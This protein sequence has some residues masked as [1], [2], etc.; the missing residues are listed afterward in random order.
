[1]R[2]RLI[3][4]LVVLL[5]S[6]CGPGRTATPVAVGGEE[7]AVHVLVAVEGRLSVKREGWTDYAP[8][9]FGMVMRSGD[10]LRLEGSS[11]ATLACAD[12]KLAQVAGGVSSVPCK[13]SKPV[14][15]YRSSL[16]TR[17]RADV[18]GDIPVV[19]S[20]RNTR[21]LNP[22]PVLRWLP[23]PGATLYKVTVRGPNVNWSGEVSGKTELQYPDN[24]PALSPGTSYK[25]TV[26]A[27][28]RSSDEETAPGLGFSVLKTDEAQ[29][30]RDAEGRIRALGLGDVP[31][32]LLI[33]NLYASQGLNAEAI[34]IWEALVKAT[35][36]PAVVR[37]LGEM[38]LRVGLNRLAEARYLEA[39]A[40]SQTAGDVEGQ[41]AAQN[42]LGQIYEVF[43]NKAEAIQ[44]SQKAIEWYQKLGDT[45]TVRQIQERVAALEK[46]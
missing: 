40:L 8:A 6:A 33:A 1:M 19:L 10:L 30:V 43:G 38:Y 29:L 37:S 15:V 24:A 4:C 46:Q 14:L 45:K 44:R 34:E 5:V 23:T 7:S 9:L 16:I 13:V 36:E 39:L 28:G 17:A 26:A 18:A 32:R 41:A 12:L 31:T 35:R 3:F 2:W 11:Q 27:G 25:V 21:L 42:A 22:R 20:P